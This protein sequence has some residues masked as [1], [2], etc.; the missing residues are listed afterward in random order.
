MDRRAVLLGF[1]CFID[2]SYHNASSAGMVR[3]VRVPA[4]ADG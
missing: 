1:A 2:V 3:Q 4:F